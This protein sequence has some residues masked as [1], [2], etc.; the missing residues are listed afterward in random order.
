M[1]KVPGVLQC[2]LQEMPLAFQLPQE[3]VCDLASATMLQRLEGL[4]QDP[5]L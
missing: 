3:H 2:L 5:R 4:M 1:L